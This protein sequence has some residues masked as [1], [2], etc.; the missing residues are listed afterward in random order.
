MKTMLHSKSLHTGAVINQET[1]MVIWLLKD[2]E[3]ANMPD[4]CRIHRFRALNWLSCNPTRTRNHPPIDL[5]SFAYT[6]HG[7]DLYHSM[8]HEARAP[9][10]DSP[11]CNV[12]KHLLRNILY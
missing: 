2:D 12:D 4:H 6:V 5:P 9:P 3:A 11:F 1:S 10:C 7:I 8:H